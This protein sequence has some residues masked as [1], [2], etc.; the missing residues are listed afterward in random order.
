M[1]KSFEINFRMTIFRKHPLATW[2]AD[3]PFATA[4]SIGAISKKKHG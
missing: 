1:G 4:E 3:R 2:R